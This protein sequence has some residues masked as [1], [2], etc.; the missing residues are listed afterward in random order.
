VS[1]V[2][3]PILTS[4]DNIGIA[5][6]MH[7]P[8]AAEVVSA[9]GHQAVGPSTGLLALPGDAPAT[10]ALFAGLGDIRALLDLSVAATH[11]HL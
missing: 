2:R 8:T 7:E 1:S 5:I 3:S 9:A 10:D 4:P 6:L 11:K